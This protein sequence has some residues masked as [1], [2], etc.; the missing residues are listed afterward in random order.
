MNYQARP[1]NEFER[2]M[3][4]ELKNTLSSEDLRELQNWADDNR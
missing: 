3:Q 2:E 4:R 1:K